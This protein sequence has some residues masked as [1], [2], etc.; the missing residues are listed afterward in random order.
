MHV[1]N[2]IEEECHGLTTTVTLPTVSLSCVFSVW[3]PDFRLLKS[4]GMKL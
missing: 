1:F 2:C 4:D 3:L